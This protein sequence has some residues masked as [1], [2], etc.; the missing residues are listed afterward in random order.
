MAD[1]VKPFQL[2]LRANGSAELLDRHDEQ[3]WASDSDEDFQQDWAGSMF[4]KESDVEDVL[5]FL[6]E[7]G[8][9][10]EEEADDCEIEEESL[11]GDE[12]S[13]LEGEAS[14]ESDD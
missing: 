14:D 9:L 13:A 1:R 8:H 7:G 12:G 3:V 4:L 5:E 10:T 2:V 11:A 6:V